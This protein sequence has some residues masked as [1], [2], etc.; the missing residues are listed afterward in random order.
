ML[1]VLVSPKGGLDSV[2]ILQSS[3]YTRLDKAAKAA[4]ISGIFLPAVTNGQPVW[5][6]FNAPVNFKL[7]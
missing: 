5:S 1:K 6:Q 3:G 2:K 7:E 4:M